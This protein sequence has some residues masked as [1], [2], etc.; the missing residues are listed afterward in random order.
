MC[1]IILEKEKLGRK[2]SIEVIGFNFKHFKYEV[3]VSYLG[4]YESG[5]K[6]FELVEFMAVNWVG[7]II[8]S[9]EVKVMSVLGC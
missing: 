1:H 4:I 2:T 6:Y 9:T 8:I 5:W 7:F 3:I